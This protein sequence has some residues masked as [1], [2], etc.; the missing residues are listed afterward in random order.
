M[1]KISVTALATAAVCI[2][3][4]AASGFARGSGRSYNLKVGD[5]VVFKAVDF[6]CQPLSKSEIACGSLTIPSSL[7]VYYSPKQLAVVRFGK[8]LK[9][10]TLVFQAR[11]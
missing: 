1:L 6:Q 9:K 7:Q 4:T 5:R 2:A 11:R 10:G 3:L 8:T